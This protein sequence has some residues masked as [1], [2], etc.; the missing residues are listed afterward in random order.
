MQ[1]V[2]SPTNASHTRCGAPSLPVAMFLTSLF[3][4][5][6]AMTFTALEVGV[7]SLTFAS[8]GSLRLENPSTAKLTQHLIYVNN[9]DNIA[10]HL[11]LLV[12]ISVLKCYIFLVF[13]L[14]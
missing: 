7:N 14:Y 12:I 4:T 11:S 1:P 5:A 6:F 8:T 10:I 2:S 13:C 9:T 3:D